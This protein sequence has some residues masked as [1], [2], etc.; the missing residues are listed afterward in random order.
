MSIRGTRKLKRPS[1]KQN[2]RD[3]K[4][5]KKN[6]EFKFVDTSISLAD[7]NTTGATH[8]LNL[9]ADGPLE[10]ERS[11]EEITSRR[12]MIRGF[13]QN[14]QGT[15]VDCIVRMVVW[16]QKSVIGVTPTVG[17]LLGS[18]AVNN[19]RN[20]DRKENIVVYL[21]DTFA[22]DDAQHRL[23]PFKFM[24]RL[25]H[26][27]RFD[28]AGGAANNLFYNGLNI[29]FMSTVTGTTNAPLINLIARYSYCD[30]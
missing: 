20:M 13:F 29:S 15:P 19:F 22:M 30:S 2:A 14:D 24:K 3:I 12:L 4:W 16:R 17:H 7:V 26:T 8:T 21:D 11:G 25:N 27:V 1:V 10:N 9:V 5:I 28:G 6:I 18:T 23:I